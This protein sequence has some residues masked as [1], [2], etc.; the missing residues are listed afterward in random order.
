MAISRKPSNGELFQFIDEAGENT[1][2]GGGKYVKNPERPNHKEL[3]YRKGNLYYHDSYAGYTR[4]RGSEYVMFN[5]EVIW[6][7]GYGGG[8]ING[9]EYL[10]DDCFNFLKKAM[11]QKEDGF[12]SF[13]GPRYFK[14]GDWEYEY[15]QEGDI[16]SFTGKEAI[17][18]HGEKV[19][20]H[21][22]CGGI[23]KTK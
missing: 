10:T 18:L 2:A 17:Y 1:Y 19:F 11:L 13:R 20:W 12:K 21:D 8:I 7:N 4:S 22:I 23:V 9:K 6:E 5:N 16:S 3:E 15:D 14:E